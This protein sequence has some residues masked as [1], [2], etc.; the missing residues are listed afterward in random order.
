MRPRFKNRAMQ[1]MYEACCTAA[2]D[3]TSEF[4]LQPGGTVPRRGAGHRNA[5]W[6]G[7]NGEPS[8]YLRTSLAHA[9]WAA[10]RDVERAGR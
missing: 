8:R 6:S 7:Y 10:G 1:A 3:R 2:V 4:W 9:A 5:F